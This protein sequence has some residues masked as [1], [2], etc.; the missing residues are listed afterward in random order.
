MK[1]NSEPLIQ[2]CDAD[3]YHESKMGYAFDLRANNWRLDNSSSINFNLLPTVDAPI[4]EGLKHTLCRYAEEMSA[5]YTLSIFHQLVFFLRVTK[6][7]KIDLK[8]VSS[9]RSMLDVESEY[10][11]AYLRGFFLSWYE[12]G[13][14]GISQEVIEYL[15]ELVLKCN[16]RGKA[17][18]TKCPYSGAYTPNEQ[19]ALLD[20]CTNAFSNDLIKL[21]AYS[22]FITLLFT[23][24]R[25]VQIRYLRFCDLTKTE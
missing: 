2:T 17:V 19:R 22:A 24:R 4:L 25:P 20:W 13:Y 12:Y 14:S 5:K 10:K 23:G 16:V 1:I 3:F 15:E 21:D 11:L 6:S 9:F 18:I 7:Q 8:T